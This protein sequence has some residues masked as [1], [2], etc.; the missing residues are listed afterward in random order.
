M[1]EELAEAAAEKDEGSDDEMIQE[2]EDEDNLPPSPEN[3]TWED[4]AYITST[5]VP[6]EGLVKMIHVLAMSDDE[7]SQL[8]ESF[9]AGDYTTGMGDFQ[10]NQ[11]PHQC[12]SLM[13]K[14]E[15]FSKHFLPCVLNATKM[16]N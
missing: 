9:D 2:D 12:L 8:C 14:A 4:E 7:F 13:T 1:R 10:K 5:G 11:V 6:S 3:V 15:I 16:D